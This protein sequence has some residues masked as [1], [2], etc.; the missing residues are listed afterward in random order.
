M[1]NELQGQNDH[2]NVSRLF[3]KKENQT[4]VIKQRLIL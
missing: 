4:D 2:F 3:V 1:N